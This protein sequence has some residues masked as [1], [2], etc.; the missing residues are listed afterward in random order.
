MRSTFSRLKDLVS[1]GCASDFIQHFL[2]ALIIGVPFINTD[3]QDLEFPKYEFRGAWIATVY[4]LDWPKSTSEI[5]QKSQLISLLD[6][7][8]DAGINAVFFQVRSFADAMYESSYEPWSYYLTGNQETPAT[9]DPLEFAIEEAHLR[10]MEIHA[11][12]NPYRAHHVGRYR[13]ANNH[14]TK[15]H[16]EWTYRAGDLIYLDPGQ[17]DVRTYITRIVMDIARRYQ[18]D[19]IHFDDYFYPYPPNHLTFTNRPD[20]DSFVNDNRGFTNINPWR[21]DNINLQIKEVSDSLRS[22]NPQLKFGVS[23]FGIWKNGVPSG[24]FGLDAYNRIFADPISWIES[25][26]IDYLVPQL[27]WKIGGEQD[28]KKLSRW[29]GSKMGDRHLYIGHALYETGR[30]FSASEVI[31]QVT[32]NRENSELIDGSVFF[33]TNH[34]LPGRSRSFSQKIRNGLYKYPAL[35]PPMDWKDS[36]PQPAPTNLTVTENQTS[37]ELRWDDFNDGHNRY[38]I[39]RV[40]STTPPNESFVTDDAQNLIAITGEMEYIDEDVFPLHEEYWY[41]IRSVSPNSIES[42]SSSIVSTSRESDPMEPNLFS[43]YPTV[44]KDQINIQYSLQSGETVTLEVYDTIGRHVETLMDR[45]FQSPGYYINSYTSSN[46]LISSG[47]YWLVLSVGDQRM[48][49]AVV[50]AN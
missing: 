42:H 1:R 6:H 23:P 21:R 15:T 10:G 41:F 9:Y 13:V 18:I 31:N 33:R 43:A 11:W 50:R 4:Q 34:L 25:K 49:R 19:G 39:Y 47:V 29:W 44:F 27:Y 45:T 3:A 24:I 12:V 26:T 7:L 5:H 14:V 40:Q 17:R 32:F 36:T 8:K 20:N 37:V 46:R 35:P 38:A 28:Y 22:F 2:I 16:P 30:K 48:T